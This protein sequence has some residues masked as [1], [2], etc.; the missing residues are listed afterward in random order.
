MKKKILVLVT[1][2]VLTL[3]GCGTEASR[4]SYNLSQ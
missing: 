3:T 2:M 4:V 1:I